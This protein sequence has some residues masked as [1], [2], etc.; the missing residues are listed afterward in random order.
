VTTS[1]PSTRARRRRAV[2][3]SLLLALSLLAAGC[4]GSGGEEESTPP[5]FTEQVKGSDA[6][7]V[8]MT[9]EAAERIGVKL[10]P[11]AS[12]RAGGQTVIPYEAVLYD[13]DGRTWT[14]T[15]PK[16][17]VFQRADIDIAHIDGDSA[18]LD[19]GPPVGARVVISGATEIWGVEYGGIEED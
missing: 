14:Y 7:R 12:A 5:A 6:L 16:P 2:A 1:T 10:S 15:S 18:F 19:K 13:P 3:A 8:V 9:P 4:G 11:V 17:N